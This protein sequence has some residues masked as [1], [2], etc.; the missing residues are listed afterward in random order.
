MSPEPTIRNETPNNSND[1]PADGIEG[2]HSGQHEYQHDQGCAALP[3]AV[4]PCDH[5]FSADD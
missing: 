5:N 1:S 4:N 3:V 2:D